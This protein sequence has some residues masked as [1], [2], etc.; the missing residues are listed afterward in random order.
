MIELLFT[1]V[2][3]CSEAKLIATRAL[4]NNTIPTQVAREVIAEVRLIAP[5]GCELPE[6]N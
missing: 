1:T 2:L 3:T 6:V 5:P 4:L